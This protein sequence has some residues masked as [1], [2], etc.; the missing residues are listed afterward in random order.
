MV[1]VIGLQF[2][3]V[4]I[5]ALFVWVVKARERRHIARLVRLFEPYQVGTAAPSDIVI[6]S[7]AGWRHG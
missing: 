4:A 7:T 6:A 5:G 1:E 3:G 2:L